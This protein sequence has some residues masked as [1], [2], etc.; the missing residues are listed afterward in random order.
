MSKTDYLFV[1]LKSSQSESLSPSV[2]K[3]GETGEDGCPG[4]LGGVGHGGLGGGG[5]GAG[6]MGRW[7]GL[8]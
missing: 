8:G 1:Q 6:H 5:G 2:L 3:G 7:Q 4:W